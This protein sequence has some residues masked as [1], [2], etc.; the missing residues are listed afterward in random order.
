MSVSV[1]AEA[2]RNR[3]RAE[4]GPRGDVTDRELAESPGGNLLETE[5]VG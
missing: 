4:H 1:P 5:N 3:H 2:R